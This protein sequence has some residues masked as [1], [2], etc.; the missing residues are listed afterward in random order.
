MMSETLVRIKA[1]IESEKLK[2]KA[3]SRPITTT[4][5]SEGVA[6]FGTESVL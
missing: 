1:K 3:I 2:S 5:Y 4:N 6:G